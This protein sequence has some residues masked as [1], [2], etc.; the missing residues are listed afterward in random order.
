MPAH[1]QPR[2]R[3]PPRRD[4]VARERDHKHPTQW[5]N[6]PADHQRCVEQQRQTFKPH[7]HDLL[8]IRQAEAAE[9]LPRFG[10][11]AG[12]RDLIAAIPRSFQPGC[13]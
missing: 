4:A 5:Q 10:G 9:R 8:P 1:P 13:P 11:G 7:L 2:Q 3:P 12:D 6:H